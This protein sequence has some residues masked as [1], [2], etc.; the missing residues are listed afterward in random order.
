MS[1]L[2]PLAPQPVPGWV[3]AALLIGAFALAGAYLRPIIQS[4]RALAAVFAGLPA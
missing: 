2:D 3:V 1:R 4:W